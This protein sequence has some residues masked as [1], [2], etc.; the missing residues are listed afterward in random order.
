MKKTK[1]S[2]GADLLADAIRNS[3]KEVVDEVVGRVADLMK[4][5]NERLL[6]RFV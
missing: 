2:G 1:F 6:K 4:D 3:Q 5:N